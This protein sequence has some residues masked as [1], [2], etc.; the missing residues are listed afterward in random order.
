MANP[1]AAQARTGNRAI[2]CLPMGPAV[3]GFLVGRGVVCPLG[4]LAVPGGLAILIILKSPAVVDIPGGTAIRPV[5]LPRTSV[6]LANHTGYAKLAGAAHLSRPAEPASAGSPTQHKSTPACTCRPEFLLNTRGKGDAGRNT[7]EVHL[8]QGARLICTTDVLLPSIRVVI[9]HLPPSQLKPHL[10]F[11]VLGS[12][13]PT[14]AII[15]GRV[16]S[17]AGFTTLTAARDAAAAAHHR[18]TPPA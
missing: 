9:L 18:R 1:R 2:L 4:S 16:R 14:T 5:P 3:V 6:S 7:P 13:M 11:H 8:Q 15:T 17:G 12:W 10:S